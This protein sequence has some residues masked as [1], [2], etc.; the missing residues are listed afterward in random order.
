MQSREVYLKFDFSVLHFPGGPEEE[1]H[2]VP[3]HIDEDHEHGHCEKPVE[4]KQMALAEQVVPRVIVLIEVHGE[5]RDNGQVCEHAPHGEEHHEGLYCGPLVVQEG[6][7][8]LQTIAGPYKHGGAHFEQCMLFEGPSHRVVEQQADYGGVEQGVE[9]PQ[10]DGAG[11]QVHIRSARGV[12]LHRNDGEYVDKS[13]RIAAGQ[14][15]GEPTR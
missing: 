1:V 13:Q 8:Q 11:V 14:S 15:S 4:P 2:V 7:L 10:G 9:Y 5:P 3:E 12:C 6:D